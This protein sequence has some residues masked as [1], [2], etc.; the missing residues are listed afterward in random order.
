[1]TS[2]FLLLKDLSPEAKDF[3]CEV[4]VLQRDLEPVVVRNNQ[5]E[6]HKLLVADKTGSI[7][8]YIWGAR[9]QAI[10]SGDILRVSGGR[11]Q[12][13]KGHLQ[14]TVWRAARV[15][16]I[17]QDTMIFAEKPNYSE[18]YVHTQ[19]EPIAENVPAPPTV[20]PPSVQAQIN[21]THHHHNQI[22]LAA[23]PNFRGRGRG[24]SPKP[25]GFNHGNRP[26]RPFEQDGARHK[27]FRPN[28][29]QQQ[30]QR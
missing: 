2:N 4:I 21:E 17:G 7:F 19:P 14:I 10:R 6:I 1:M 5:D 23:N 16:R 29:E 30:Q 22:G 13:R 18:T 25:R 8:M 27:R 12:F 11:C 3:D 24:G 9:A 26:K 28:M 15:K 20:P